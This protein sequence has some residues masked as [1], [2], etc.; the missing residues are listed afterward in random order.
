MRK[1]ILVF[2]VSMLLLLGTFD[3]WSHVVTGDAESIELHFFGEAGQKVWDLEKNYAGILKLIACGNLSV[4]I[5]RHIYSTGGAPFYA[6]WWIAVTTLQ[7]DENGLIHE[8]VLR[9]TYPYPSIR[10][11]HASSANYTP[12]SPEFGAKVMKEFIDQDPNQYWVGFSNDSLHVVGPFLI[13]SRM[14]MD[15]GITIILDLNTA[16]L[17]V[18][19][20]G[21]WMGSGSLLLPEG[22]GEILF[23]IADIFKVA[24]K[25]G[26]KLSDP[27]W[28][29]EVDLNNDGFVN[30]LDIF[31]IARCFSA[32]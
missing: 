26:T 22:D 23:R 5:L 6:E 3:S 32:R 24:R 14:P 18:A 10:K 9:T 17:M 4:V 7:P 21:V 20:T 11:T 19:A 13:Y 25:F 8:L 12:V 29:P 15:F 30:I 2:L 16:N 31:M 1:A 28:D 27:N